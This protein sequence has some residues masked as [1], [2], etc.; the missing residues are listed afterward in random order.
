M[1]VQARGSEGAALGI[2]KLIDRTEGLCTVGYFDAPTSEPVIRQFESNQIQAVLLPEQ[3]R[4]YHFDETVGAWEIG[5]IL[6]DHGDSQLIQFPNGATK[7][8]KA[9]QVF[10]RWAR[11]IVDPTPFL[12]NKINESPRF[13]DGRS[14]FIRSQMSQRAASMGMSAL[15]ASA[16]ELEAHQIEV[17]RRILQDP[18]QRYLLADEVGLGKTIEAGILIR[19]C[20]LDTVDDFTILVLVPEPLIAQW[21]SEL[22]S[23]FFLNHCQRVVILIEDEGPGIPR[24]E[25]EKVFEPFYRI[26]SARDPSTGGVGLGLSVTRSIIW[27]HGGEINLSSR[28]GGGLAVRVHLPAGPGANMP[29]EMRG[30]AP[31]LGHPE[32]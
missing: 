13:S 30:R 32:S 20:V 21:R 12:A 23:K 5:R 1:F 11:E 27:E 3:T 14:A 15:L 7:H 24:S 28:K 4:V 10:V 8:L 29:G 2:G 31:T 19:Q 26:G 18:V 25:R 6:G 17:V 9:S 16:V 22:S